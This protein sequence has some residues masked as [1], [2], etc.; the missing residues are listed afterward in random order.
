M[1]SENLTV[2]H[3]LRKT[4]YLTPDLW[5]GVCPVS[6][7]VCAPVL[8]GGRG[9]AHVPVLVS[10]SRKSCGGQGGGGGGGCSCGWD[11]DCAGTPLRGVC[12]CVCVWAVMG[13]THYMFTKL[14]GVI[15]TAAVLRQ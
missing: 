11:L 14:T 2:G 8:G 6:S 15:R 13:D 5:L 9:R 1:L 7:V 3:G 10:R 4:P 12:V